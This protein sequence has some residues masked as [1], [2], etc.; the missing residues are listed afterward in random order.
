MK[1][2]RAKVYFTDAKDGDYVYKKGDAYPREGLTVSE[3]RIRELSTPFNSRGVEVIEEIK[4]RR[5]S[6][7]DERNEDEDDNDRR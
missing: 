7:A 6:Y 4:T 2:Y 1:R 5:D 3:E